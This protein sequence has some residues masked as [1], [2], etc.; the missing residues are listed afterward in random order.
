[1]CSPG[2]A[3]VYLPKF[4]NKIGHSSSWGRE[5]GI[6]AERGQGLWM[7]DPFALGRK[8]SGKRVSTEARGQPSST[9]LLGLR[10]FSFHHGLD[11]GVI[12]SVLEKKR[13]TWSESEVTHPRS[14]SLEV[15]GWGLNSGI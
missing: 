14:H 5:E 11:V 2:T 9:L 10:Y 12:D 1:M 3:S 6:G 15:M 7:E 4:T 13:L 8:H